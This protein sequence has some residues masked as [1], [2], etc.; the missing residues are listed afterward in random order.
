[1]LTE[2]T[3]TVARR[4]KVPA[5]DDEDESGSPKKAAHAAVSATKIILF[6]ALKSRTPRRGTVKPGA[7]PGLD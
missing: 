3:L 4:V 1:M 2:V 7:W 5:A 6:I